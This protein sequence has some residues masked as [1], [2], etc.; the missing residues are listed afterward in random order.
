MVWRGVKL[1]SR[2]SSSKKRSF[3]VRRE[4]KR[5]GK[6]LYENDRYAELGYGEERHK[7]VA[8]AE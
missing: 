3:G 1:R 5:C 2:A 4:G 8:E 7:E 6:W